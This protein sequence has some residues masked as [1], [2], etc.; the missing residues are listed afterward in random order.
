MAGAS[1]DEALV[2]QRLSLIEG[3]ALLRA[4]V[5]FAEGLEEAVGH[6][7]QTVAALAPTDPLTG[8]INATEVSRRLS[9][10]LDRDKLVKEGTFEH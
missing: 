7:R 1:P 5:G 10:I 4:G 2:A 6:L 8:L 3:E 9:T